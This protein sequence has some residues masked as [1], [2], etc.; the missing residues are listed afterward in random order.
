MC[1]CETCTI[2][3]ML[4]IALLMYRKNQ[5]NFHQNQAKS[6][7]TRSRLS[8]ES[9]L[10]EYIDE[11]K[12]MDSNVYANPR[13]VVKT[14]SCSTADCNHF[15]RWTCV[16]SRCHDCPLPFI[17]RMELLENSPL[18]PIT[19][20]LYK[21]HTKC[22]LHGVLKDKALSCEHCDIKQLPKI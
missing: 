16:M 19:Y 5:V 7:S 4:N 1:G 12:S 20:G 17:P 14:I 11:V 9:C 2:M 13:D 15:P 8:S 18:K 10:I 3:S 21:F 22:K 6:V